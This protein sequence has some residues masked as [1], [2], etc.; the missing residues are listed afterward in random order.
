MRHNGACWPA[1]M[2]RSAAEAERLP[3]GLMCLKGSERMMMNSLLFMVPVHGSGKTRC[4]TGL[5]R[6]PVGA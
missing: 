5:K 3:L 6:F 4:R 2:Q 1:E